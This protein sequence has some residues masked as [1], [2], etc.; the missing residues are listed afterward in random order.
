MTRNP[1]RNEV[2]AFEV[3]A[4]DSMGTKQWPEIINARTDAKAKAEYHRSVVDAGWE[5]PYTALRVR[6]VG[7]AQTDRY[8]ERVAQYRGR[9]ELKCGVR[10]TVGDGR[11]VIVGANASANFDVLFDDDSPRYAG[12]RLNCHPGSIEVIQ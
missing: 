11:G 1:L 8:C 2:F 5:I 6:K 7:A 9:P 3:S 10:V 4:R 12:A